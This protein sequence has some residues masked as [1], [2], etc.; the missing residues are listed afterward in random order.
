RRARPASVEV[1]VLAKRSAAVEQQL[2]RVGFATRD[3]TA[4]D[5]A[6][7][8]RRIGQSALEPNVESLSQELA[9]AVLV[10]HLKARIDAGLDGPLSQKIRAKAVDC[11]DPGS[12]ELGERGIET[13]GALICGALSQ[14]LD[15]RSQAQLHLARGFFGKS[16]GDD[17]VERRAPALEHRRNAPYQLTGLASPGCGL[18]HQRQIEVLA[19]AAAGSG[20]RERGFGRL[21]L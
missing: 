12:F 14:K 2:A 4:Q 11:S 18:D 1:A 15:F 20:V 16:D 21:R 13:H 17:P 6:H 19:D 5:A 9:R 8:F 10:Q 3:A 7:A